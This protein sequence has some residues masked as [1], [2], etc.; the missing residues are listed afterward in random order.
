MKMAPIAANG[1][2]SEIQF[3]EEWLRKYSHPATLNGGNAN[4]VNSEVEVKKKE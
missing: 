1:R 4:K 3:E 2:A